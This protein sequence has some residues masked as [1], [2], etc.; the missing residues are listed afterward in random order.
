[1]HLLVYFLKTNQHW[2]RN[3]Q[4]YKYIMHWLSQYKY[5]M[6]WLSKYKYTMHWLSKFFYME[7][8]F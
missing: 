2:S 6:H 8:K 1:M 3:F 4:Q 5:I 7:A